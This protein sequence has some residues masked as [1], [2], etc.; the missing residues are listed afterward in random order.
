ML[1]RYEVG[2]GWI[3]MTDRYDRFHTHWRS[4][5]L[6]GYDY[7]AAGWYFV[8]ICTAKRQPVF[9]E[10]RAGVMGLS[11]VGCVAHAYWAAIL[12][13]APHVRLD[14]FI[15]MPNHVHGLI[16]VLPR[17]SDGD[18][19]RQTAGAPDEAAVTR[20]RLAVRPGSVSAV[21]RSYKSAVT[22]A[23]RA[24]MPEFKWQ[25]RF[26]DHVVRNEMALTHIRTYIEANPATWATDRFHPTH[27]A[28]P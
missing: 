21:V 13:H 19:V 12:D 1:R 23:V 6:A 7:A 26:H 4:R 18:K 20:S 27:E 24:F 9:G 17:S 25:P 14:A 8:T 16:G 28:I 10:I 15:V 3:S 11:E 2:V 5:R 22:K